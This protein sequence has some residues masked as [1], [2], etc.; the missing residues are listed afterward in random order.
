MDAIE[1][2]FLLIGISVFIASFLVPVGK[3]EFTNETSSVMKKKMEEF[4]EKEMSGVKHHMETAADEVLENSLDK[5][6]R[7]LER[8]TNEKIMAI[9]EYSDVVLQ[10]IHKNHEEVVFLYDMLNDKYTN[11]KNTVTELTKPT[12]KEE[13]IAQEEVNQ[14]IKNQP[15]GKL[16]EKS[17]EKIQR[18]IKEKNIS[19]SQN[20]GVSEDL[21]EPVEWKETN[22]D[23]DV[24]QQIDERNEDENNSNEMIL[25]MHQEGMSNVEIAKT[26]GLGL[27]EVKLVIALY[28]A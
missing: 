17:K 22:K 14:E 18:N 12:E 3:E 24:K 8:L 13:T 5:T 26:L 7:S 4:V 11:L 23:K 10:E 27:G 19:A 28:R 16:K 25:K 2:L 9:H 20:I 1:I 15:K 6:E 21:I